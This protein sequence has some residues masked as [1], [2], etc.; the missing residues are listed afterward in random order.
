MAGFNI[1]RPRVSDSRGENSV[2]PAASPQ[3][4]AGDTHAGDATVTNDPAGSRLPLASEPAPRKWG[5]LEHLEKIGRGEFGEVYRAWDVQLERQVALK[6][7]R[8]DGRFPA[9]AS[10]GGLGV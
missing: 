3:S 5:H 4:C 7:S 8:T 10:W 9:S 2:D 1:R 6:L